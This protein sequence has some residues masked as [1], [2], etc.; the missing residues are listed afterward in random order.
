[1]AYAFNRQRQIDSDRMKRRPAGAG[2]ER[3]NEL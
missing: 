1:M 2:M 3:F